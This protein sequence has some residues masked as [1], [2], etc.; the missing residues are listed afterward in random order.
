MPQRE[1]NRL[2]T[3]CDDMNPRIANQRRVHDQYE[4]PMTIDLKESID[5]FNNVHKELKGIIA[6]VKIIYQYIMQAS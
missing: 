3:L 4:E 1:E 5:E 6:Q 2:K